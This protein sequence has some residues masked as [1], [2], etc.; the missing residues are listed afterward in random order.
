MGASWWPSRCGAASGS[1]RSH[2]NG[3]RIAGDRTPEHPGFAK[4]MT[5]DGERPLL[6]PHVGH[7]LV[8]GLDRNPILS[9]LVPRGEPGVWLSFR[10]RLCAPSRVPQAEVAIC[11]HGVPF[12]GAIWRDRILAVQFLPEHSGRLGLDALRAFI[13]SAP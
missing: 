1:Y 2:L 5:D 3:R 12:A 9:T 4:R 10:H 6:C 7:S 11:H 13:G 8:V